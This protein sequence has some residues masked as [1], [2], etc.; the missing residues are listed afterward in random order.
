MKIVTKNE[1]KKTL[2]KFFPE[3]TRISQA[4]NDGKK[5]S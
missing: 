1:G 5:S 3:K 4:K 2:E